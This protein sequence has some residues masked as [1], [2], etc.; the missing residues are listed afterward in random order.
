MH[1]N[2]LTHKLFCGRKKIGSE[3]FSINPVVQ[4]STVFEF[5]VSSIFFALLYYKAIKGI[6]QMEKYSYVWNVAQEWDF[7][8]QK[9]LK[10]STSFLTVCFISEEKFRLKEQPCWRKGTSD[11]HSSET[12]SIIVALR[13]FVTCSSNFYCNKIYVNIY[14]APIQSFLPIR[15]QWT[16]NRRSLKRDR[17]VLFGVIGL[18]KFYNH[19]ILK[20][21]CVDDWL[22]GNKINTVLSGC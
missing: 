13:D 9:P 22:Q 6:L 4:I 2:L 10:Y 20:V 21:N 3:V 11:T 7:E 5:F 12:S 1:L 14:C 8:D 15:I 18:T 16:N 17:T 19:N